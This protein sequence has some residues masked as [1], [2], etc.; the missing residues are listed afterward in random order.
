VFP[1]QTH[2]GVI[3]VIGAPPVARSVSTPRAESAIAAFHDFSRSTHFVAGRAA[4]ETLPTG[5]SHVDALD[6]IAFE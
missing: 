6:S 4:L 2:N 3:G 1:S 5:Q